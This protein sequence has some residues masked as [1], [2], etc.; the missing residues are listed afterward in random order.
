MG[1]KQAVLTGRFQELAD[2]RRYGL[3]Q[4]TREYRTANTLTGGTETDK[5]T[6][7]IETLANAARRPHQGAARPAAEPLASRADASGAAGAD[8]GDRP[9]IA[10]GRRAA[11]PRLARGAPPD[12]GAGAGSAEPPGGGARRAVAHGHG[13][14]H[15]PRRGR[16]PGS[17]AGC[18]PRAAP[19]E[20][21]EDR[22]PGGTG[23]RQALRT[24]GAGGRD[25]NGRAA[26][27]AP[28][29]EA[30]AGYPG[31][32]GRGAR[33]PRTGPSPHSTGADTFRLLP[34]SDRRASAVGGPGRPARRPER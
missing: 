19:G 34:R 33:P 25:S 9:D 31:D 17:D 7:F 21:D 26:D 16:R 22:R 28:E 27:G 8:D 1:L 14:G 29:A 6:L 30:S 11:V 20:D 5:L 3:L 12:G 13:R 18:E 2:R 15:Q 32:A 24:I 23:L 10:G 4:D